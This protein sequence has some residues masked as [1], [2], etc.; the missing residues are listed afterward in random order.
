MQPCYQW[1]E[2]PYYWAGLKAYDL[3]ANVAGLNMSQ[4]LSPSESL[5]KFPMLSKKHADGATLKGTVRSSILV[6]AVASLQSGH[7][8]NH[9]FSVCIKVLSGSKYPKNMIFNLKTE[10]LVVTTQPVGSAQRCSFLILSL[11]ARSDQCFLF[12]RS[13]G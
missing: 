4:Y 6:S 12:S 5:R 7:P 10:A 1:W 11:Q 8:E 2:V 13:I 9:S 3:V